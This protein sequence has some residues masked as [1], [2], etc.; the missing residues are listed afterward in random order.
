MKDKMRNVPALM[1]A[2]MLVIGIAHA[3]DDAHIR[4]QVG[5]TITLTGVGHN[6]KDGIY[7]D[8]Y[9]IDDVSLPAKVDGRRIE[10]R[11]VLKSVRV[12]TP[13]APEGGEIVQMREGSWIHL[14]IDKV[15]WR[16]LGPS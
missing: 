4:S 5:K 15:T 1:L 8:S 13:P 6:T 14:V 3:A 10:V 16:V 7:L 11:G 12:E 2:A 9:V